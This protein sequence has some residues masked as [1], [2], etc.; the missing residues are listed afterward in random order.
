MVE[1]TIA[2]GRVKDGLTL[3]LNK[4]YR[5]ELLLL[6]DGKEMEDVEAD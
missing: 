1:D 5:E 2:E 6:E 3:E 4:L